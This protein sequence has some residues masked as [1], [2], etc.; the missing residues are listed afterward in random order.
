MTILFAF[1][2]AVFALAFAALFVKSGYLHKLLVKLGLA[3][4]KRTTNWTAFSW[5]S[6]LTKMEC[7]AEIVFLGDSIVRGGDFHKAFPDKKIVNLGCSGDTLAGMI[8]RVSTVKVLEPQKVFLMAGINGLTDYNLQRCLQTYQALIKE[9]QK[10]LPESQ[11]YL[12]SVLPLSQK[13]TKQICK[14]E[15]I[16][17]FNQGI[18]KIAG[19]RGCVFVDI[20][21]FYLKNG[22]MDP[23]ITVDGLHLKP[24]GYAPWYEAI[25]RYI[26]E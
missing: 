6:C 3:S 18:Q 21:P 20:Y 9:L 22:E 14:N 4:Q 13:K 5:E 26:N 11:V 24:E 15:T 25:A 17:A 10:E 16:V 23:T 19:A 12:M 1:S 7:K 8:G 2:T